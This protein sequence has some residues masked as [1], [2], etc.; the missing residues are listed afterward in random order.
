MD[1][2]DLNQMSV[3]QL[4]HYLHYELINLRLLTQMGFTILPLVS[5]FLSQ[6]MFMVTRDIFW[7]E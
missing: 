2:L 1:R 3:R 6:L 7:E 4:N 5:I